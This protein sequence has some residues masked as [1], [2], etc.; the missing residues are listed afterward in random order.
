MREDTSSIRLILQNI[1][2]CSAIDCDPLRRG[3]AIAFR[4]V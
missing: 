3:I 4:K 2:V 1:A